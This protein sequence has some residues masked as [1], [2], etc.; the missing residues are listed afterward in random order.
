[1][2]PP[3]EREPS[4]DELLAMAYADGELDSE[5]RAEIE[6]RMA[7]EPALAREVAQLQG[8]EVLARRMAPAE[9]KDHEWERLRSELLHSTGTTLAWIL[10]V[11]GALGLALLGLVGLLSS[12]LAPILKLCLGVL[13]GGLAL[14]LALTLRARLRT[15]PYDPYTKVER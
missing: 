8:L 3:T 5:A 13:V 14:L 9:P 7:T 1:M 10:T 11:V 4:R 15:L 6:Q 12:D 2:T